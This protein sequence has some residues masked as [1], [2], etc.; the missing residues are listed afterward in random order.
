MFS[1]QRDH[2]DRDQPTI[3]QSAKKP[4]YQKTNGTGI[5]NRRE[6]TANTLTHTHNAIQTDEGDVGTG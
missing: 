1:R 5:A 4:N 3:S 2:D 6:E